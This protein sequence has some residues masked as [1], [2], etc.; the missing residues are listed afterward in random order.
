M[1]YS[2]LLICFCFLSFQNIS[3]GLLKCILNYQS[4]KEFT[5]NLNCHIYNT[6][7]KTS[8]YCCAGGSCLCCANYCLAS[9]LT[10]KTSC[11]GVL[12]TAEAAIYLI[13]LYEKYGNPITSQ[14]T[15]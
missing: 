6:T 5:R 11:M 1:K 10:T 13:L 7:V 12:C 14:P 9:Y 3:S 4:Q 8:L 15:R 2:F